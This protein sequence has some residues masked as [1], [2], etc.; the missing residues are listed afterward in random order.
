MVRLLAPVT[1]HGAEELWERTGHAGLLTRSDWPAFDPAL[2]REEM[3][4]IVVQV[5][6]KL[7]DRFEAVPDLGEADLEAAA[8]AR[9]KVQAALGGRPPRKVIAV[10]NKLVNIVSLGHS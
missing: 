9:P 6:G 4:T 7:R 8:L 1:P 10:K 2:A 5:D 3:A